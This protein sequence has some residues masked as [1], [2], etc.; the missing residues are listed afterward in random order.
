LKFKLLPYPAPKLF[1][2]PLRTLRPANFSQ[3]ISKVIITTYIHG[4]NLAPTFPKVLG[5]ESA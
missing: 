4:I 1:I 5:G 2:L 3:T